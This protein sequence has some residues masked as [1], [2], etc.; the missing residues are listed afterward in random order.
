MY[1][2]SQQKLEK[3]KNRV[4]LAEVH[5]VSLSVDLVDHICCMIEERVALGMNLTKAEDDVIK[6]MGEAQLKAI[7]IETKRLTQNKFTMK[8]RTKIIGIVALVLMLS[9]FIMKQLHLM[10]AGVTWGI[11]VLLAVFG[12]ALF[13]TIDNFKYATSAQRKALSV[14]GYVGSAS[15]ILGSGFK[16]LRQPGSQYMIAIGGVALLIYFILNNTISKNVERN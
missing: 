11:G 12:F 8:K 10:G 5:N 16:L 15:F 2:L 6:E 13:L 3:I 4:A 9:G 7:E 1:L 14:I